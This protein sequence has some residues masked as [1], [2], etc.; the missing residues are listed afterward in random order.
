MANPGWRA[1]WC[2]GDT[3]SVWRYLHSDRTVRLYEPPIA[4][5]LDLADDYFGPF[6]TSEYGFGEATLFTADLVDGRT[7]C[8]LSD[9]NIEY[10]P[11]ATAAQ[12]A[13]IAEQ[14]T[15]TA[16]ESFATWPHLGG[17]EDFDDWPGGGVHLGRS[18]RSP[19]AAVS[20]PVGCR[21]TASSSCATSAASARSCSAKLVDEA[22]ACRRSWSATHRED[23]TSLTWLRHD[24]IHGPHDRRQSPSASPRRDQPDV[25]CHTPFVQ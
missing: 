19:A 4:E 23:G 1:V 8:W 11:H 16:L 24:S 25:D 13:A 22:T 17:A 2:P 12:L 15:G 21:P 5:R 9:K 3:D 6:A 10:V 14:M 20:A 18:I 7:A